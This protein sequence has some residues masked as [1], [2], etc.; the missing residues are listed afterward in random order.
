MFRWVF[1]ER[2]MPPV[3]DILLTA[4]ETVQD[5]SVVHYRAHQRNEKRETQAR[6]AWNTEKSSDY[7]PQRCVRVADFPWK[8]SLTLRAKISWISAKYEVGAHQHWN[9]YSISAGIELIKVRLES[10]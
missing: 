10:N 1:Q 4:Q 8:I 3:I 7:L 5:S 6:Q 2:H 9:V